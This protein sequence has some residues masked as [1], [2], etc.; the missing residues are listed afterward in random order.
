MYIAFHRN[1]FYILKKN[2][3]FI[4]FNLQTKKTKVNVKK[5]ESNTLN[6]TLIFS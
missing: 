3:K 1:K 6:Y 5:Y 4:S 2:I